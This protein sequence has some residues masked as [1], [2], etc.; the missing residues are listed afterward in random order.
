[1]YPLC[2]VSSLL[3]DGDSLVLLSM[4]PVFDVRHT[5]G[6][7]SVLFKYGLYCYL[8]V[9]WDLPKEGSVSVQR[10]IIFQYM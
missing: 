3:A 8:K 6:F 10:A 1:M 5:L 2:P 4:A 7:D 9:L